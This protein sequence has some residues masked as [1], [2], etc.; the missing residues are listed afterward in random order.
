[1][2]TP[3]LSPP[4]THL[5]PLA[6]AS[7]NKVLAVSMVL[8]S[9]TAPSG[10]LPSRGSPAIRRFS[11]ELGDE[12]IGDGI[13]DDD[14]LSGHTNLSLIH[15]CS[16]GGGFDGFVEVCIF[17]YK[18]RRLTAEFKKHRLE[19]TSRT[20]GH[21]ATDARR[22]GE[23]DALHGGMVNQCFHNGGGVG[24]RIGDHVDHAIREAGV[25]EHSGGT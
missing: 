10:V 7:S 18:Q 1:M 2:I 23:V 3:E 9:T 13:H 17:K 5:A 25:S 8:R 6:S 20:L 14:A 22:A 12:Y 4:A 15:E 11:S 16:E 24:R 19:M 21:D